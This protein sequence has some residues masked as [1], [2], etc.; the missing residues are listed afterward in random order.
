MSEVLWVTLSLRNE[1]N[2]L[3]VALAQPYSGDNL[4]QGQGNR[5]LG[6]GP[7]EQDQ[8]TSRSRWKRPKQE[9]R[10][11]GQEEGAGLPTETRL[12]RPLGAAI[13]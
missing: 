3:T 5:V 8:L 11:G 12:T 4:T 13:F 9:V 2:A 1:S 7:S 10:G 6:S